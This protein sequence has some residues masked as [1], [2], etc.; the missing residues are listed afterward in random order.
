MSANSHQEKLSTRAIRTGGLNRSIEESGSQKLTST[1][2]HS[3]PALAHPAQSKKTDL[4]DQ[5]QKRKSMIRETVKKRRG[6]V[7]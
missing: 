4:K 3:A 2:L 1:P 6:A 7:I 5:S